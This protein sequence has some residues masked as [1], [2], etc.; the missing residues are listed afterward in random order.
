MPEEADETKGPSFYAPYCT[1]KITDF[2][3]RRLKRSATISLTV[4][5]APKFGEKVSVLQIGNV[6]NSSPFQEYCAA[7][8]I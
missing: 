1:F 5:V 8:S 4:T 3:T 2:L 6:F 7:D